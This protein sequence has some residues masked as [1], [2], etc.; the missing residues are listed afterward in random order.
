M[1]GLRAIDLDDREQG[2]ILLL[3]STYSPTEREPWGVLSPLQGT[4]VGTLL[5]TVTGESLSHALHGYAT[6]LVRELG[7]SPH[8]LLKKL[9]GGVS[10]EQTPLLMCPLTQG[11]Q[12][13]NAGPRCYPHP[14][15][16]ACY[17]P[18]PYLTQERLAPEA[19]V[20]RV[21]GAWVE[22]RYVV[23]VNGDTFSIS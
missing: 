1:K 15:M 23:I 8:A 3:V 16:P 21:L 13:L 20:L 10:G 2:R 19:L 7:P 4:P 5:P 22:G 9:V 14:K 18:T 12:C 11:G 6:P 17:E